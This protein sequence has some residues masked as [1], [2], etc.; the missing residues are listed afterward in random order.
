MVMFLMIKLAD[1][2]PLA[3]P[4]G[5]VAL[6]LRLGFRLSVF[7]L[8]WFIKSI[9]LEI[10]EA[11]IIDG[12]NPLQ[13]FLYSVSNTKIYSNNWGYTKCNVYM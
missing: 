11:S 8:S 2:L 3:N 7:M 10:E 13:R 5:I 6:Y 1:I 4:L 9:Y 12:W